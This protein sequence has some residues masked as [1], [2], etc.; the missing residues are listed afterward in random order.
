MPLALGRG[1]QIEV[2]L[3]KRRTVLPLDQARIQQVVANLLNNAIKFTQEGG[4]IWVTLTREQ[5]GRG[6]PES[7]I[8]EVA[9]DGIGIDEKF[10]PYVFERFT[11]AHGGINRRY[12]GLGLGLAIIRSMVE[13]HGG[14]VSASSPG[15]GKGSRFKVMLPVPEEVT[16][17]ER[18]ST[19]KSD[20]RE[21]PLERLGL[22]VLIIEDSRDTLDML[23]LWLDT[24]G[25][26][27]LVASS[28]LE[29][30]RLASEKRPD[31]IIS[32]IGMP[33]VD[34]YD[35]IQRLRLTEGLEH[36]PAIALTGYA[37]KQDRE[38]ALRA[39]YN[40]HLAKP[41]RMSELLELMKEM[42]GK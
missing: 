18:S 10:L 6:S 33:D 37:Q 31:L 1:L 17:A 36:T 30:L 7:V 2:S 15:L 8:I 39:G 14:Q 13:M 24:F 11:Q 21:E 3:P 42:T 38:H 19:L 35:L 26:D 34:G 20:V 4:H 40:A 12:G 29:G 16:T 5:D 27:V 28:A 41:A 25:C 9:D 23:Q 32:D 22:R